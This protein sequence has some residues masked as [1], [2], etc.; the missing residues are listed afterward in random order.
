M[1]KYQVR[2][3]LDFLTNYSGYLSLIR[4]QISQANSEEIKEIIMKYLDKFYL[5]T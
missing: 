2:G 4:S 5:V 1:T 3:Y